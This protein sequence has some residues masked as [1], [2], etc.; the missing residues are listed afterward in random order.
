M[1]AKVDPV[2]LSLPCP[3]HAD[4]LNSATTSEGF[5]FTID[6]CILIYCSSSL[7][8]QFR[9]KS[10]AE[11]AECFELPITQVVVHDDLGGYKFPSPAADDHHKLYH[12]PASLTHMAMMIR[13]DCRNRNIPIKLGTL[14]TWEIKRT[15]LRPCRRKNLLT[16]Q[17]S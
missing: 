17:S 10:V 13:T 8:S 7:Y 1:Q 16:A 5:P 11:T 14:A 2:S 4:H 12:L 9:H 6:L 3:M 15:S